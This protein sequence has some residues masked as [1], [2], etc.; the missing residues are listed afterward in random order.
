MSDHNPQLSLTR[1]D[2]EKR[3]RQLEILRAARQLFVTK[4]FRETTLDEIA[5]QAEFGKG[6][7]YNY[8][9]S[10]EE[11]LY[12]IIDQAIEES[13]A[14]TLEATK[15]EGGIRSKLFHYASSIIDFMKKNGELIHIVTQEVHHGSPHESAPKIRDLVN[16]A[17]SIARPLAEL[18]QRGMDEGTIR[19]CDPMQLVMLFDGMV[20]GYIFGTLSLI[21]PPTE[22]DAKRAAE[23]IVSVFLEG[24][25]E[26]KIKG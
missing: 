11:I 14:I 17:L 3:A 2:R 12:L 21:T 1:K 18:L 13:L 26:R 22:D 8:F 5:R 15:C 4:G 7:L 16:R 10:K 25:S 19:R 6:T 20:R 23:L 9:A 24:I